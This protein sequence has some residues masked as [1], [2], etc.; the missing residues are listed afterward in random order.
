M[1]IPDLTNLPLTAIVA[2]LLFFA[3]IDVVVAYG[4]ALMNGNFQA[5]YALD[6]LRTHVLK[7]GAPV[8]LLALIGRGVP[9]IGVPAI[10]PANLAAT[11]SLGIYILTVLASVKDSWSDKAVPPTTTSAVSPVTDTEQT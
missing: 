2:T 6:F 4:V 10:P 11:A 5:A 7:V 9:E 3:A 8:I 1:E